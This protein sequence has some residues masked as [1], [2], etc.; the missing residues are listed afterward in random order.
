MAT[1]VRVRWRGG[2]GYDSGASRRHRK[3]WVREAA[4]ALACYTRST[5]A[6]AKA[7]RNSLRLPDWPS[8]TMVLVTEVPMLAPMMRRIA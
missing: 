5:V 4:T 2:G 8:A 6:A 1:R 7:R 3:W